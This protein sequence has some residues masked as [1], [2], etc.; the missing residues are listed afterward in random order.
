[1]NS[2]FNKALIFFQKG[3]LSEAKKLCLEIIKEE[4]NNF[5]IYYI[6]GMTEFR[7][8]EYFKSE[9][10]IKK[11]IKLKPNHVEIYNIYAIV[12]LHL[13]KFDLAI[14]NWNMAIKL[15]PDYV[16]AYN[17]RGNLLFELGK[18]VDA[19]KNFEKAIELK[20]DFA[21]AYNNQGNALFKLKKTDDALKSYEKAIELKPNYVQ[22]YNNRGRVYF[23]KNK[24]NDALK[25][26]EKAIE[27]KPDFAEAYF[28]RG[29]IFSELNESDAAIECYEKAI[30]FKPE[31]EAKLGVLIYN[32][33]RICDWTTLDKDLKDIEDKVLKYKKLSSPFFLLTISDSLKLQKITAEKWFKNEFNSL[34]NNLEIIGKKQINKKI[35]I[36]YYSADFREH[37]VGQLMV[38]LFEL[39]DKSKFEIFGFY[40]GPDVNDDIHKR[41]SN[42]VDKFINVTLKSET[43]IAQLSRDFEID[44]AVD[45]MGYTKKNRFKIFSER[46]API[47]TAYLGYAGTTGAHCI[48]YLIADKIVI[49][50][51]NQQYYSE[52]IIY[53]PNTYLVN[54]LKQKISKKNFTREELNLPKNDFVFCCF[55]Q[56]YKILPKIFDMWMRIL[57]RVNGSVLWLLETNETSYKNLKQEAVKRGVDSNRIIFAKRLPLLEDHLERYKSADL[58]L[59]TFPYTAHSTCSDSL[60]AGLPVLTL[61]GETFASRVS[62]SLL[63]VA[64]LKELITNRSKEYEDMAVELANNLT[65]LKNIKKKLEN[66]KEKSYLFNTKLFTNHIEK[67][68]LEMNK[69]YI[70]NKKPENIEIK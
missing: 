17:N 39:H 47:Q 59:D 32:K 18:N 53:L 23:E 4:P 64:D 45:L 54:E 22:A 13:K 25:S 37:A 42:A 30:K 27:L 66:N 3:Q 62:S 19:L 57:K 5:D 41:I 29:N 43:E 26:Y 38:N 60:K 69:K 2:K 34:N 7:L 21:E 56:S 50:K 15:K 61:Q 6:L 55:N 20:P 35:K 48:D 49:P 10:L 24:L 31:F 11:A 58:F 12:L 44:I 33:Q 1:M 14:E 51:E 8:K 46:C 16:E 28:D 40:F 9:E 70:E 67:A 36:G 65:R 52:K 68:Y 63:E